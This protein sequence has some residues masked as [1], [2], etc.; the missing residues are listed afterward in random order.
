MSLTDVLARS[1][2][3][4]SPSNLADTSRA[5]RLKS[6]LKSCPTIQTLCHAQKARAEGN[7][8][9]SINAHADADALLYDKQQILQF[10]GW[11]RE[12]LA[13]V[14]KGVMS[15]GGDPL[16]VYLAFIADIT[17]NRLTEICSG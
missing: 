17:S 11:S 6:L 15:K 4:F 3:L 13:K 8:K 12:K 5:S 10:A 16:Y 14:F 9:G 7:E 2:T 1:G